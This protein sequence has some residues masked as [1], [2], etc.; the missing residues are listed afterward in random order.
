MRAQPYHYNT[1]TPGLCY[2][3]PIV[4]HTKEHKRSPQLT[5][6][7]GKEG[8]ACGSWEAHVGGLHGCRKQGKD[9]IA[10]PLGVSIQVD[11]NLDLIRADLA[12]NV[13]HRP[14]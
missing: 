12:G 5:N 13:S 2:T 11:G 9:L 6:A 4:Q 1:A 10:G 14:G 7:V 8:P 3:A